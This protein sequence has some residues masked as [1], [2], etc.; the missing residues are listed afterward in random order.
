MQTVRV[1]PIRFTLDRTTESLSAVKTVVFYGYDD[2]FDELPNVISRARWKTKATQY[3]K[4]YG[5]PHWRVAVLVDYGAPVD[6]D[7]LRRDV[8]ARAM[9]EQV[10]DSL[11]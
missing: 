6:E 5:A 9:A 4:T 8:A 3:L 7:R 10:G 1:D 2:C 11:K